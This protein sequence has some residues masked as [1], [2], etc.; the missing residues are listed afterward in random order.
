VQKHREQLHRR[1][2]LRNTADLTRWALGQG[3]LK[4]EY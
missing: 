3:L 2:G 1:L 4:N